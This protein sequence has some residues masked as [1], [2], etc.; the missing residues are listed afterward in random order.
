LR[1]AFTVTAAVLGQAQPN[2]ITN[3]SVGVSVR[4]EGGRTPSHLTHF[5]NV[6]SGNTNNYSE[7]A[8]PD[9]Q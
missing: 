5:G 4:T 6:L 8:V 7:L 9:G 3:N 2:T 1:L